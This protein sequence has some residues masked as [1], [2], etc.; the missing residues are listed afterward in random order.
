MRP[1]HAGLLGADTLVVLDEAHLVPAFEELL[2][3]VEHGA[4]SFRPKDR[5]L[6]MLLPSFRLLS[7]SA[8][9]RQTDSTL[10]TITDADRRNPIV[11]KRLTAKKTLSI[12]E[13]ASVVEADNAKQDGQNA[14][15]DAEIDAKKQNK[16][17][18]P[19]GRGS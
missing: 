19:S 18:S 5:S 9:G 2:R 17:S 11:S 1:Y 4:E 12:A 14:N 8:T 16:A 3:Q 15:A 7:L 6:S 10:V 13:L